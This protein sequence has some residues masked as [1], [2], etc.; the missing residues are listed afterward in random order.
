MVQFNDSYINCNNSCILIELRFLKILGKSLQ[1]YVQVLSVFVL[2]VT[3]AD[4][5][6]KYRDKYDIWPV[7]CIFAARS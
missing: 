2:V 1:D 6:G 7:L 5:V 3:S 4:A